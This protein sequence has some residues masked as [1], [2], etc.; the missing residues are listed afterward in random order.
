[1]HIDMQVNGLVEG[2][3]NKLSHTI[4][5]VLTCLAQPLSVFI[6]L[7]KIAYNPAY[8]AKT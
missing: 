5:I 2:Q 3:M 6:H 1:M 4:C 7:Q 8:A